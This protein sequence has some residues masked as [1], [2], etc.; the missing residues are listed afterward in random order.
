MATPRDRGERSPQDHLRLVLLSAD[1]RCR[2]TT[3]DPA[4]PPPPRRHGYEP[5]VITGPGNTGGRWTPSDPSLARIIPGRPRHSAGAGAGAARVSRWRS[6]SERW[7]G[8]R[9]EWARW[10]IEGVVDEA[11]AVEGDVALVYTVI[12]PYETTEACA[13]IAA[14][15]DAP[16]V[17]DLGDPWALDDMAIYP[18]G[19][20]SP[21]RA[22]EDA[23]RPRERD[24]NRHEHARG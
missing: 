16:W 3:A 13:R 23:A 5:I 19:A 8:R 4:R 10:W 18:T 7:L 2:R 1:R 12:S 9:S 14:A 11:A 24:R 20:A 6:R 22:A 15:R 17:P 21:S